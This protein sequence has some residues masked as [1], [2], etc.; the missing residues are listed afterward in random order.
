MYNVPNMLRINNEYTTLD[1]YMNCLT[2]LFS[3]LLAILAYFLSKSVKYF[4]NKYKDD[5]DLECCCSSNTF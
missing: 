4:Y 3:S 1:Y 5:P 2:L